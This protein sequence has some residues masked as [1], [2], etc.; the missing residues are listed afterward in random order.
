MRKRR[1]NRCAF[2]EFVELP[3]EKQNSLENTINNA[4]HLEFKQELSPFLQQPQ[5]WRETD[6]NQ[7]K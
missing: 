5:Q 1:V 2:S 7:E 4:K 3:I 6:I